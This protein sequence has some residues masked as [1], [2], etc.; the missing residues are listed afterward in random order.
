MILYTIYIFEENELHQIPSIKTTIPEL[1]VN[2]HIE[3][4]S[5]PMVKSAGK[6]NRFT[7]EIYNNNHRTSPKIY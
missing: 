4:I 5:K 2:Y 1:P 7:E 3:K 6:K